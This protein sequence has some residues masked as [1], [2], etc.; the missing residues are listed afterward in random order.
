MVSSVKPEQSAR[1]TTTGLELRGVS[2]AWQQLST[3]RNRWASARESSI[4][5]DHLLSDLQ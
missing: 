5:I 3:A 2:F 4:M 1:H